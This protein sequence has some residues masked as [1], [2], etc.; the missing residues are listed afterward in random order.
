MIEGQRLGVDSEAS[1]SHYLGNQLVRLAEDDAWVET[2]AYRSD[3]SA[4]T[5]VHS[6]W[7]ET[8]IRWEQELVREAGRWRVARHRSCSNRVEETSRKERASR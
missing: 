6:P 8:A 2:Y 5:G 4:G 7:H 1:T 3:H